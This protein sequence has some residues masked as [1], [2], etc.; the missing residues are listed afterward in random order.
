MWGTY[1]AIDNYYIKNTMTSGLVI[2]PLILGSSLHV[3]CGGGV[4]A[5]HRSLALAN[6]RG[7]GLAKQI[8]WRGLGQKNSVK[9]LTG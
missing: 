6:I 1:S 3:A 5:R 4:S 8:R 7:K 2:L 9:Y